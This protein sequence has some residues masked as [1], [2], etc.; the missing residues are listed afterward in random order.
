MNRIQRV[1]RGRGSRKLLIPFFTAGFPSLKATEKLVRQSVDSGADIVELG[2][3]FS[4][5][6]A[7]GLAIQGSSQIALARG[8]RMSDLFTLV[9]TINSQCDI[10]IVL[11][12][13]LNPILALG[14]ENFCERA[15]S[16][17]VDGLIIPDLPADEAALLSRA[18]RRYKL[19][20]IYLVAPTSTN[21][22]IRKIERLS[23]D[24]IYA[25]TVTGVTGSRRSFGKDTQNYLQ[26][27]QRDLKKPFVAGFGVSSAQSAR[28]MVEHAD[29]IVIGSALIDKINRSRSTTGGIREVGR[30]LGQIRRSID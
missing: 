5:P 10:P 21:D 14:V 1:I 30:L 19:S 8:F 27:L 2:I 22:S 26:R 23:T 20:S 7:D 25:V 12:G 28:R 13:Y 16:S 17:G 15:A 6:I 18:Q 24:F 3:P 29:G 11:M 9:E 4:D